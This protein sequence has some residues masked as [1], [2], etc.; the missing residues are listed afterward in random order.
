MSEVNGP[1]YREVFFW[2]TKQSIIYGCNLL[3]FGDQQ[4]HIKF[5]KKPDS[6]VLNFNHNQV[7]CLIEPKEL[8]T[9]VIK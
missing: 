6:I 5:K 7:P 2:I 4:L 8:H 3:L 9:Y 1:A